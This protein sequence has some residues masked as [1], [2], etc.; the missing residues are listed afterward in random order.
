METHGN[1][2]QKGFPDLYCVHEIHKQRW[3]EVKQPVKYS[4]TVA[5]RENFPIISKVAGIWI[6]T[7]ATEYEYEKL[8]QVPNWYQ[9][10]EALK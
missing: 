2:Y 9:Y 10:L 4:F 7:A 8:F 1:L 3:I 5:Q 6:L